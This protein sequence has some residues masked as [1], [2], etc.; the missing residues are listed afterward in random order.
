MKKIVL[1]V[2]LAVANS[3]MAQRFTME[4]KLNDFEYMYKVLNENY[5]YFGINKRKH[6][7]DWLANKDNYIEKIKQTKTDREYFNTLSDALADLHSG[8]A[9][10]W[11][12][13]NYEYAMQCYTNAVKSYSW[14]NNWIREM[15]MPS[16]RDHQ[17]YWSSMLNQE[18][19]PET[20]ESKTR[21]AQNGTVQKKLGYYPFYTN[22]IEQNKIAYLKISTFAIDY[23]STTCFGDSIRNF[24]LNVKDYPNIIIDIQGNGG[25]DSRF[26]SDSIVP[27]L[28]NKTQKEHSIIA[29]KNGKYVYDFNNWMLKQTRLKSYNHLPN[30]VNCPPELKSENYRFLFAQSAIVPKK[31]VGFKGK[32]YLLVDKVVYSSSEQ[33]AV[34]AKNTK[35]ATVVGE[36]TGGDGIGSNSIVV[37]L[38]ETGLIF[39]FPSNMGLNADGSSN[40]EFGTAPD[41]KIE[42]VDANERLNKLVQLLNK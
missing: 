39:R 30:K 33:F 12:T 32:I 15:Q 4:Q 16:V 21:T 34:F 13:L 26:W 18:K 29:Q 23:N 17:P 35:W 22:I 10:F 42:A 24:L 6:N 31:P 14:F 9:D 36:N 40:Y 41:I 27:Y 7:T 5:P 11:P 19:A 37:A 1:L 20:I 3:L 38:P 8:H 2:F 25:G 28:L